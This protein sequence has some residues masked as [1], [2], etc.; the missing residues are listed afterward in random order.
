MPLAP[1]TN[2]NHGVWMIGRLTDGTT[3]EQADAVLRSVSSAIGAVSQPPDARRTARIVPLHES[4]ISGK[5]QDAATVLLIATGLVL[6]M[7]CANL[8]GLL[9]ANVAG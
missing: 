2:A 1:S 6:L 3:V 9:L 5:H 7:A 8:G 4:L